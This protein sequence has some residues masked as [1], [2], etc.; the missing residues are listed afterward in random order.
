MI[1]GFDTSTTHT[2]VQGKI[3]GCQPR[4]SPVTCPCVGVHHSLYYIVTT[5]IQVH[6]TRKF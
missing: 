6:L 4:G 1:Y 3:I 2:G 5:V